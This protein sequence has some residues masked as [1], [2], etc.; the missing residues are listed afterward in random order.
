MT[1]ADAIV[2]ASAGRYGELTPEIKKMAAQIGGGPC[3]RSHHAVLGAREDPLV[4]E[5]PP[6]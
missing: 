5:W 3:L 1:L 2:V 6:S 4:T